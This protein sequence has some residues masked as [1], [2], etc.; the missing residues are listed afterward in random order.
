[1]EAIRE[2]KKLYPQ[3]RQIYI[4]KK[5]AGG[6]TVNLLKNEISG[7]IPITPQG[8]K[9]D[10]LESVSHQFEGG[11]IVLL[12]NAPWIPHYVEEVVTFP[13]G[14]NDDQCDMTSQAL[15]VLTSDV[16]PIVGAGSVDRVSLLPK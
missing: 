9:V 2:L 8:S 11:N 3:T 7:I 1:L 15:I 6:S 5:A 12:D 13:N 16:I 10:R 4:E 14:K